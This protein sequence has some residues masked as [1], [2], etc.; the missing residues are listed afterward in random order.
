MRNGA[1]LFEGKKL[2]I[3]LVAF[4]VVSL[5][6]SL[7]VASFT[8][9]VGA[10]VDEDQYRAGE[11]DQ[12]EA[13]TASG[14]QPE[15]TTASDDDACPTPEVVETVSGTGNQQT[16]PFDIEG[17]RFLITSEVVGTGDPDFL[18]F[19]IFV[20][21]TNDELNLTLVDQE[22][23]GTQ[24]SF[25]NEGP[26]SFFLDITAAN[27]EYEITVE[28][29]TGIVN[30]DDTSNDSDADNADDTDADDDVIQ[31]S[32]PD[33]ALPDTGGLTLVGVLLVSFSLVSAV[34]LIRRRR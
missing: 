15:A 27:A 28:D 2:G 17:E 13:T 19:S 29:C 25:V 14:D 5:I 32:I 9:P 6:L 10:Q 33:K 34:F 20:E 8:T 7:A 31:T 12:P 3:A 26:G 1:A 22:Q 11:D 4:A 16:A 24:S 23:E 21:D 18:L 30:D